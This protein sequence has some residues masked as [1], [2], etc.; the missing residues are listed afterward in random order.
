MERGFAGEWGGLSF[1]RWST[2]VLSDGTER[3]RALVIDREVDD[4]MGACCS[5]L[6]LGGCLWTPKNS[7]YE[8]NNYNSILVELQALFTIDVQYAVTCIYTM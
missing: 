1:T 3:E 4:G 7:V 5:D 6:G 2:L 8:N